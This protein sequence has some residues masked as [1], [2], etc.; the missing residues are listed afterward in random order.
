[1]GERELESTVDAVFTGISAELRETVTGVVSTTKCITNHKERDM[2]VV[3]DKLE[4]KLHH[5]SATEKVLERRA[6][7]VAKEEEGLRVEKKRLLKDRTSLDRDKMQ[8][9]EE[10][11]AMEALNKIT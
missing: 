2:E 1:M 3:K 11:A 4:T 5:L 8:L 6:R 7:D 9:K 10:M